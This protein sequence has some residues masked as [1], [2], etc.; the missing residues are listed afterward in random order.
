[1]VLKQ[2]TLLRLRELSD[3][4][5]GDGKLVELEMRPDE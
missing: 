2:L 3:E 4:A 5:K 1:V